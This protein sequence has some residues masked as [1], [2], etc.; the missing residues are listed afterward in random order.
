MKKETNHDKGT[1]T[2]QMNN[3]AN[4]LLKSKSSYL[5]TILKLE[6]FFNNRLS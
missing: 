6:K 1:P 2:S 3:I 4:A 5:W